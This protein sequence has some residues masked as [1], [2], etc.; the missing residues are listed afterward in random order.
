MYWEK[1]V[2]DLKY[3]EM[4]L[5]RTNKPYSST[6]SAT[7]PTSANLKVVVADR[8]M[9]ATYSAPTA[10]PSTSKHQYGQC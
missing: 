3:T 4:Q 5:Y 1:K 10:S 6:N 2:V 7:D 8:D 9:A